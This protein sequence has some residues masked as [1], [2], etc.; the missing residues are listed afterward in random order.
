MN[1][2]SWQQFQTAVRHQS[3]GLLVTRVKSPVA[4]RVKALLQL[5]L[6]PERHGRSFCRAGSDEEL[7]LPDTYHGPTVAG[8]TGPLLPAPADASQERQCAVSTEVWC[9]MC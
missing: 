1:G 4:H 9:L 3:W 6:E 5:C 8:W 2:G 7:L